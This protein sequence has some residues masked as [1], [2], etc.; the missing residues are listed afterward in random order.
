MNYNDIL[1]KPIM[2]EKSEKNRTEGK[3]VFKVDAKANKEL[4]KQAITSM[5]D[6]KVDKI[7][8]L[9]VRGKKKKFRNIYVP[10]PNWKKAVITLKEGSK[11]EFYEGK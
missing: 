6:V 8:I 11:L 2:S 4:I 3:Y 1:I 5:F 10:G 9:N 7:N